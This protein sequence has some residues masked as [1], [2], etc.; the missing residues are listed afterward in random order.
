MIELEYNEDTHQYFVAGMEYPSVTTILKD[1]DIIDTRWFKPGSTQKG[2]DIHSLTE[3][4][5]KGLID[6]PEEPK[7]RAWKAFLEE[8]GVSIEEIELRVFS[9]DYKVAGTIDRIVK[10]GEETWLIDI[11]S[12]SP[13]WWHP[14]QVGGYSML[15]DKEVDKIGCVYLKKDGK[16]K[17]KTYDINRSFTYWV[18]CLGVY[19]LRFRRRETCKL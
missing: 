18:S 19:N 16:Y 11:K 7:I 17:L 15:Y 8:T 12:G 10:Q 6:C 1:I 3:A 14:I 5:D 2:T 13:L 4:F 9:A